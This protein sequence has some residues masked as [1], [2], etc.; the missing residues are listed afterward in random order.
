MKALLATAVGTATLL[1][2]VTA[3]AAK[4]GPEGYGSAWLPLL[5]TI[6][7]YSLVMWVQSQIVRER[8]ED[9]EE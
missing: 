1:A 4:A 3:Y 7:V 5:F 8:L 2:T 9:Q 6:V